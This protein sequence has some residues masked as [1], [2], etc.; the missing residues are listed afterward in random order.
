MGV[1]TMIMNTRGKSKTHDVILF[2][3]KEMHPRPS[4]SRL[5]PCWL[6]LISPF[7]PE[8]KEVVKKE[9]SKENGSGRGR[10]HNGDVGR[11]VG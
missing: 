10:I 4:N 8:I 3:L 2:S 7:P 1:F 5:K 6:V 9:N 11:K